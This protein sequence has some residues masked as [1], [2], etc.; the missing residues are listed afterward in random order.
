[1]KRQLIIKRLEQEGVFSM[2]KE[3]EFPAV[4][5]RIAVISSKNAAGYT[6]FIN[7]LNRKQFRIC[8]LYCTV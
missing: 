3:L 2:N 4:P 5:Q 8:I 1:M 6:D 7:H